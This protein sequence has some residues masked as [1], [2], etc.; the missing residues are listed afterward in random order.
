MRSGII[1]N[2]LARI[3]VCVRGYWYREFV[4]ATVWVRLQHAKD[5]AGERTKL[6]AQLLFDTALLESG[7]G[8]ND[9]KAFNKRVYSLVKDVLKIKKDFDSSA[10]AE[11]PPPP[12]PPPPR[13]HLVPPLAYMR[14]ISQ[15]CAWLEQ[16]MQYS[17]LHRILYTGLLLTK[18]T[19]NT[20]TGAAES[21]L[22]RHPAAFK[23]TLSNSH[24]VNAW[25]P[26]SFRA[27]LRIK[28]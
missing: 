17:V 27:G 7:F 10:D 5:P 11:V 20:L 25:G 24:Q 6:L 18:S 13:H 19:S 3:C 14:A 22:E 8:L 23:N 2:S 26:H 4:G 28:P 15:G 9:N 12:P 1:G 16:P 21:W